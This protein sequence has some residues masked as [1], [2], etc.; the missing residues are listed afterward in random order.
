MKRK[1]L[2][3]IKSIILGLSQTDSFIIETFRVNNPYNK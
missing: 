1:F 3:V 2:D